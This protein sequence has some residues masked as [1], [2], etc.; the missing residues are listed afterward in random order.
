[1]YTSFLAEKLVA[2][3]GK[4]SMCFFFN[5]KGK[6]KEKNLNIF[7]MVDIFTIRSQTV[8]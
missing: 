5:A 7:T 2:C 8:S 4:I 1:M 3:Y 6:F